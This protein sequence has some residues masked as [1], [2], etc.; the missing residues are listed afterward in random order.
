VKSLDIIAWAWPM[1][2]AFLV[3]YAVASP[4]FLSIAW[5]D[6][7]LAALPLLT[8]LIAGQGAVAYFGKA[9]K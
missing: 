6:K 4:A 1:E 7:F 5:Y 9:D 3:V 2:V 8:A